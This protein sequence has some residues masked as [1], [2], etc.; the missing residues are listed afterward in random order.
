MEASGGVLLIWDRRVIAKL[1]DFIGTYTVACSFRSLDDNF[2][3]AFAS[4]YGHYL[5]SDR[6]HLWDELAGILSCWEGPL[7]ISM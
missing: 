7:L 6:S 2:L 3:W 4:V 1:E 5:G